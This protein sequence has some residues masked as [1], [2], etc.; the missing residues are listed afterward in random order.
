M[1]A[2]FYPLKLAG[3][4]WLANL[5]DGHVGLNFLSNG[6]HIVQI[7]AGQVGV[8][9]TTSFEKTATKLGK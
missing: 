7:R 4:G 6:N 8:Y 1:E 3:H 5:Q 9:Y 2:R